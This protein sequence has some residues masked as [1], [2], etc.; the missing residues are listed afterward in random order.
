MKITPQAMLDDGLFD[1][2]LLP[3]FTKPKLFMSLP[4]VYSGKHLNIEGVKYTRGKKV[5][6][7]SDEKLLLELD[8]EMPGFAPVEVEILPKALQVIL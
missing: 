6:I 2:T 5:S 8:G 3:N 4:K 1:V 7:T